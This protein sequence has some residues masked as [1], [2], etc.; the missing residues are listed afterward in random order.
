MMLFSFSAQR[1]VVGEQKVYCTVTRV[2]SAAKKVDTWADMEPME[3]TV[4]TVAKASYPPVEAILGRPKVE[5]K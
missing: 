2:A 3:F 5:S 1:G 4:P